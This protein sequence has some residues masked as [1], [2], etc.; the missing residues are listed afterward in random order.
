MGVVAFLPGLHGGTGV[1]TAES[2]N[3]PETRHETGTG[4]VMRTEIASGTRT[5]TR[6]RIETGIDVIGAASRAQKK[7]RTRTTGNGVGMALAD[8]DMMRTKRA[9]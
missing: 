2:V 7:K 1:Q 9:A 4:N 8:G 3:E 5:G 6:T